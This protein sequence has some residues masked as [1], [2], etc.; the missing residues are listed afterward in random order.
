MI[1]S[2]F[3]IYEGLAETL[4]KYEPVEHVCVESREH[5]FSRTTRTEG[6]ATSQHAV[7]HAELHQRVL[8]LMTARFET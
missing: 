2:K 4:L 3:I 1:V 5:A 6:A 8:V 7:Q